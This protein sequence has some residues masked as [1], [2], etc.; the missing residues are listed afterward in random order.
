[1]AD[2]YAGIERFNPSASEG[3]SAQQVRERQAQGLTNAYNNVKTKSYGKIV[4]DNL[5]TFFNILNLILAVLVAMTGHYKDLA[6]MVL[7]VAN[8]TIGLVQEIASK[9]TLDKLSLLVA[10]TALV[11][12]GGREENVPEGDVVLDDVMILHMGDQIVADAIVR[13]GSIE[14]NESLITGESDI[15]T[16]RPGDYL[17]SGSFVVSGTGRA[18]VDGVGEHSFAN[19]I[20]SGVKHSKTHHSELR[21]S[22]NTILKIVGVIVIPVGLL[23]FWRQANI[24]GMGLDDNILRTVA[25]MI[26]MIPEGLFLL[27]S[28][29]L[30]TSAVILAYKQTLVQDLYCIETLARVDVLCLDKTG[31]ITEGKMHVANVVPLREGVEYEHLLGELAAAS[32]DENSTM[33]AIRDRFH[34]ELPADVVHVIPFSSARKFSGASFGGRGTYI[35]GAYGFVFPAGGDEALKKQGEALAAEGNRVLVLAHSPETVSENELP[36]GLEPLCF[37]LIRDKIRE[38]AAATL[39]Y[40]YD[41]GVDLKIIS[42]DSEQ[43]VQKVAQEVGVKGASLAIDAST[44]KTK[45][46]LEQA[47]EKYHVFGRVTPDQKKEMV[48]ALEH[49]GHTVAMTGD[50]VNDVLALREADCSVAM[51]SGSEAAKNISTLV[52]LDSDF[53]HMPD[54][55]LQGRK[56]VNNIQRVATLFITKTIYSVL[57]ALFSITILASGYPFSPLQLTLIAFTTIGFPSFFLALEPNNARV[58]GNFLMNVFQRSLPGG[59]LVLLGVIFVDM[60][61]AFYPCTPGEISTLCIIVTAWVGFI[62]VAKV[63]RP[64]TVIREVILIATAAVFVLC[65]VLLAWFFDI[66]QLSWQ[67]W[68]FIAILCAVC[69]VLMLL[70]EKAVHKLFEVLQ[71]RNTWQQMERR[72]DEIEREA[73]DS[74]SPGFVSLDELRRRLKWRK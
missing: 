38:D 70:M 48:R 66:S 63:S 31:T 29:A 59:V 6:F 69:P 67:Q 41:Q 39:K 1:M 64:F 61:S 19:R 71:H 22:V 11:V 30:A 74:A 52:L 34:A 24:E 12:R 47:V 25:A 46:E 27:T 57:L 44:L 10:S 4:K 55:V 16:K 7:I 49:A 45:K 54:I 28:M 40:F 5:L 20:S 50:G 58:K 32:P 43:T 13:D 42:G 51:A 35:L 53:A 14:V 60:F 26:G 62:V 3:L 36:S 18:V 8:T 9:R 33:S 17:Y 68:T 56:V 73:E 37:V 2:P 15:I 72:L 65:F 21:R 23:M